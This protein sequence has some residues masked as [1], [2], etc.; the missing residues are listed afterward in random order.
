MTEDA[1]ITGVLKREGGS[2]FT[3]LATDRGGPTKYGITAATLGAYRGLG[4]SATRQEVMDLT[5]LTPGAIPPFGSL[6]GLP[7]LCDRAL[8]EHSRINFN[9]GDHS[10]SVSMGY[11]DYLAVERPDLGEFSEPPE[12][13]L[14]AR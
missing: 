14:P 11:E 12:S 4:R 5:G 2:R 10:I 7:T 3:D 1:I 13:G 9:A 6:F 8:A